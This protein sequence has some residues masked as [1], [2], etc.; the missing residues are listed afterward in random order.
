MINSAGRQFISKN[1]KTC[2]L[3]REDHVKISAFTGDIPGETTGVADYSGRVLI[4]CKY[5]SIIY[6]NGYYYAT[7][8]VFTAEGEKSVLDVYSLTG[9]KLNTVQGSNPG[10]VN[11]F[12]YVSAADGNSLDLFKTDGTYVSEVEY[13]K[14]QFIGQ[15]TENNQ[16][17]GVYAYQSGSLYGIITSE[18][19][20]LTDPVYKRIYNVKDNLVSVQYQS[21]YLTLE[22]RANDVKTWDY[23]SMAI[24]SDSAFIVY[25]G[26]K[27]GFVNRD[28]GL[29]VTEPSIDKVWDLTED[30]A[31]FAV[32]YVQQSYKWNGRGEGLKIDY[33]GN[34]GFDS[35]KFGYVNAQGQIVIQAIYDAAYDFSEGM[36]VVR[37]GDIFTGRRGYIDTKGN[38]LIPPVFSYAYSFEQGVACVII[39]EQPAYIDKTG[40]YLF[41]PS[42]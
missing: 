11:D 21:E 34:R 41:G 14:I 16:S 6:R 26:N 37:Y 8:T 35:G 23:N 2:H 40:K 42:L 7:G 31:V 20:V 38:L 15:L 10:Y 4:P 9:I 32:N 1:Y 33:S 3:F 13:K 22:L 12:I 24:W 30:M 5:K 18:L 36:A 27:I 25:K 28:S 39:N 19:N 29:V 17:T